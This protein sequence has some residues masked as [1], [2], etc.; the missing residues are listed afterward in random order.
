M[1]SPKRFTRSGIISSKLKEDIFLDVP[2]HPKKFNLNRE[3]HLIVRS[4]QNDRSVII[5]PL[6]KGS[7]VVVWDRLDYLK[8]DEPELGDSSISTRKL[9]LLRKILWI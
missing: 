1:Y 6:D 3:V 9:K 5:K 7:A 8:E 4:P 2:G